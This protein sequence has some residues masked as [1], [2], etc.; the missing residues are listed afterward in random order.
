MVKLKPVEIQ[1]MC[2]HAS[3]ESPRLPL[4]GSATPSVGIQSGWR[5]ESVVA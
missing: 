3:L 1:G 4:E 5:G 2:G